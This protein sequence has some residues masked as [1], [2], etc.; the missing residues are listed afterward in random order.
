MAPLSVPERGAAGCRRRRPHVPPCAEDSSVPGLQRSSGRSGGRGRRPTAGGGVGWRP[1]PA[2][3]R[4]GEVAA[5]SGGGQGPPGCRAGP[6]LQLGLGPGSDPPRPRLGLPRPAGPAWPRSAR[7]PGGAYLA[8]TAVTVG[9]GL[10]RARPQRRLREPQHGDGGGGR[11][12]GSGGGAGA[13]AGLAAGP[14][15]GCRGEE[16]GQAEGD[17]DLGTGPGRCG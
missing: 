15:W 9:P 1:G 3:R 10:G 4:S 12:C 11:G 5:A 7:P 6:R 13:G 17:S 8:A 14:G 2:R 16:R